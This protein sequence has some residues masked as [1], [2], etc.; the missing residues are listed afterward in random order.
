MHSTHRQHCS[1]IPME[2]PMYSHSNV[3]FPKDLE[4]NFVEGT[5]SQGD[6]M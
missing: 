5:E 3:G 1:Q 4:V 2:I 6:L